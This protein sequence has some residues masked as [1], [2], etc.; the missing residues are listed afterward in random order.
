MQAIAVVTHRHTLFTCLTQPLPGSHES[1]VH[2]LP[3]SQLGGAE[4][5]TQTFPAHTGVRQWCKRRRRHTDRDVVR[6][7]TQPEARIAR[8]VRTHVAVVAVRSA[9]PPTQTR[10]RRHVSVCGA[11][12]AVV[13]H[14]DRCPCSRIAAANRIA[15]QSSS[16]HTLPSSQFA[17]RVALDAVG[18]ARSDTRVR[19]WCIASPSV[20]WTASRCMG[21]CSLTCTL[22]ED[23]TR[24]SS[25]HTLP[26]SQLSEPSHRRIHAPAAAR[27]RLWCK[28]RRRSHT[29]IVVRVHDSR[30]PGS[31]ESSVHTLPSSQLGGEP[32]THTPFAHAS[33]VVQALP[34]S[35]A[36]ALYVY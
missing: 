16:V 10:Q 27:V 5:P 22:P 35:H 31:H 20:T 18:D 15:R 34:S 9:A 8:I 28:R 32:P 25:V 30:L 12:V 2:T 6:A 36:A 17:R 1:S 14:R 7:F 33:A 4:P 13:T 21:R 24:D 19:P 23:R 11:S 29:A 26:S 3:S